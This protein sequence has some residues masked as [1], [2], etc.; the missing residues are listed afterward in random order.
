MRLEQIVV[1]TSDKFETIKG[2]S[3]RVLYILLIFVGSI[4]L[5]AQAYHSC[6]CYTS[7]R[8][9]VVLVANRCE[10]CLA[11]CESRG[12]AWKGECIQH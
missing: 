8:K 1:A 9:T 6:L 4:S 5:T 10:Q 12:G 7:T 3:M 2:D 11:E